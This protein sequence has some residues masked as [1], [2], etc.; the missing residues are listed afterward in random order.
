MNIPTTLINIP[1]ALN[2][3]M[4]VEIIIYLSVGAG[5]IL[6]LL[7]IDI[8]TNTMRVINTAKHL[9]RS[10]NEK[11]K[12]IECQFSVIK[13]HAPTYM[14]SLGKGGSDLLIELDTIIVEREES[15]SQLHRLIKEGNIEEILSLIEDEKEKSEEFKWAS[16]A[17]TLIRELGN[18][19]FKASSFAN[20][21]GIPKNTSKR[22]ATRMNL[23]KAKIIPSLKNRHE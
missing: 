19:I 20:K 23:L 12:K 3:F 5:L 21:T 8:I 15:L 11:L 9:L 4:D 13:A 7:F 22:E 10:E 2:N 1:A 18:K 16:R 14:N 6:F 17:D